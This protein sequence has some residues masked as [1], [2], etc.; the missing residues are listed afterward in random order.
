MNDE[1][2][3]PGPP[4]RQNLS[5]TMKIAADSASGLTRSSGDSPRIVHDA[6][7][8]ARDV[9]ARRHRGYSKH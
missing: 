9:G 8:S 4:H 5:P 6:R 7:E 2:T 1:A 3:P